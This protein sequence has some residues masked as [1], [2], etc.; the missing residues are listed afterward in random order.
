MPYDTFSMPENVLERLWKL[1]GMP[2]MDRYVE[3]ANWLLAP[4][5]TYFPTSR[6]PVAITLY[7]LQA[8]ESDLPWSQSWQHRWFR[9]KWGRWASKSVQHSRIVF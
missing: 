8:F 1:T 4:M 2:R 7:D 5:E 6:C 3:G 9:Y